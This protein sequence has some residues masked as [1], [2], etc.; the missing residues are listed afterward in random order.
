M[1]NIYVAMLSGNTKNVKI[2]VFEYPTEEREHIYVYQDERSRE[3]VFPKADIGKANCQR[4]LGLT[5]DEAVRALRAGFD[6]E[7]E[8]YEK[9]LAELRKIHKYPV[10]DTVSFC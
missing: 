7:A 8:Q 3:T 9:Q 10:A 1:T 5:A 6:K 4:G 2:G